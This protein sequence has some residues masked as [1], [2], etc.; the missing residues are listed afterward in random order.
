MFVNEHEKNG[1]KLHT[2]VGV[3]SINGA[4]GKVTGVV[5]SDG[6]EIPADLVLCAIGV[7]PATKFLE[8]SGIKTD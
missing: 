2:K 7:Q 4:D 3:S 8:G 6:T 5:L 1:V